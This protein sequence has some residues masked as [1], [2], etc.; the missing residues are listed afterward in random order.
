MKINQAVVFCIAVLLFPGVGFPGDLSSLS[1]E[2]TI[3]AEAH[4]LELAEPIDISSDGELLL[5]FR[6]GQQGFELVNT[7]TGQREVVSRTPCTGYFASISPDK[8]YVCFKDFVMVDGRRLQRPTLYEIARQSQLPLCEPVFTAGNPVVSARGQIAFTV[9]PQLII[10]SPDLSR[11]KEVDLGAV[12]NVLT[13][14]PDGHRLAFGEADERISWIEIDSGKR[15]SVPTT[16]LHGYQ[17]Q[18]SP[19][20]RALLARSSSGEI[21]ACDLSTGE[22][23]SFGAARAAAWVDGDTVALVR[24][25]VPHSRV[26]GTQLLKARLSDGVI[27]TF[28]T[29][30]GNAE[31]AIKTPVAA[32]VAEDGINLTDTRTGAMSKLAVRPLSADALPDAAKK[33]LTGTPATGVAKGAKAVVKLAGVPYIH[34]LYDTAD[35]FPGGASCNATAALMAIQYYNRLPAHPITCTSGGTHISNYGFYI[36]S[37]YTYN[38]HTYNIPS[39]SAWGSTYAGYYG[40]FGYFLQDLVGS[41]LQ[42]SIRLKEWITYH[43]LSSATDDSVS[44]ETGITKARTE[45]NAGYPVVVLCDITSAGHYLT[46]IGYLT[47][48]HT[49]IFNDPYGNKAISYPGWAGAGV[50]YD[51]PGYNNGYPNLIGVVRYIYARGTDNAAFVSQTVTNGTTYAPGQ[52]FSCTWTMNNN[53]TTTWTSSGYSLNYV[54]GTQMGAPTVNL[55]SANVAPGGNAS[56]PINFT[57]PSTPGS[58]TVTMRMN[59]A[60][61]AFFGAQVSLTINVANPVPVITV[62]PAST[63]RD[64]GQTATFT[65]AA[66]GATTYQWQKNGVNLAGKTT[67]TLTLANVQLADAGFYTVV[68]GNAAGTVTSSAAQLVVTAAGSGA[69]T[70]TGLRGCYYDNPDF[71]ALRLSRLDGPVNFDWGTGA[72]AGGMGVD[73][74]S[75]RWTGQ[76]QPRYSQTYTFYTTTDDGVRLWVNGVLLIDYWA[77]QAATER[78]G[79]IALVAGQK[80]DLRLE[81]YENTGSAVAQLRWSSASQLKELIP[82]AQLYRPAP[83]LAAVGAQTVAENSLLSV[84][85]TLVAWD[86]IAAVTPLEDFE[87]YGD[88]AP[89]DQIMFRKPGSSGS[90]SGFLDGAVTNY[91]VPTGSFPGGNLS[92]RAMRVYWSFQAGTTNPWLRLTTYNAA[93]RPNPIVEITRSLWFDLHTD[94]ALQVGLGLRE[95]NPTGAIGEDGGGS[96]PIEFVG[97]SGVLGTAPVPERTVLAGSWTTLKFDL[98][99]EAVTSFTGNGVLESTTGKAVLE[100]LA[101]VPAG[102]LGVYNVYLDNFVQVQPAVLSY[103][104]EPG[105]PAGA[106]IDANTGV[107]TWQPAVGQGPGTYTITVRVRDLGTPEVSGTTSFTVTVKAAPVITGQPQSLGVGVGSNATFTVTA[108]GT[109][110]LYYQ[111]R[112]DGTAIGGATGS[113]YTRV[114]VQ[115]ADAGLYSVVVSNAVGSVESAAAELSVWAVETPPVIVTPPQSQTVVAGTNVAFSVV[116]TGTAPLWYQWYRDGNPLAGA[117]QSQY[118]KAGVQ[119]ADAGSYMV[120]V[121]N[122]V[123]SVSSDPALLIVLEPPVIVTPPQSQAVV[124]GTN[125]AFSVVAAGTAPLWYQWSRDGNPL[126]GATQSQYAKASVQVADAGSY[127]VVVSNQVGSVTSGAAVLTVYAP[128]EILVQPVSQAVAVGSEASF[129]VSAGGSPPLS[130]QWQLNG[131]AVAGATDSRYTVSSVQVADVGMYS[132]AVSNPY[133]SVT[134]LAA[135]LT[136]TGAVV[137]QDD[138]ET[139]DLAGWTVAGGSATELEGSSAQNHTAGGGCSARVDHSRDKMYHNLGVEV[140]GRLR[141]GWWIYDG[142]QSRIFG[143]VRAYAGPGYTESGQMQQ[144]LGAGKYNS[145]TLSGEVWD[146][147]KYQGRVS[148]GANVGWFNLN[149][150]GAPGRSPGWHRFEIERLGDGTT[151][152][153][154]VDGILGRTIL[155]AAEATIDTL[156]IGSVASGSTAGEGWLDDVWVEY[157]DAPVIVTPPAGQTV[158]AGEAATLSVVAGNTVLSY[159]WYL[160]GVAVAGATGATLTIAQAQASDAGSYTVVVGNGL[161][162][163]TG[164]PAELV[165]T[166]PAEV[167]ITGAELGAGT[168]TLRWDAQVGQTYRVQYK[169]N[170][171][172]AVWTDGA[173]VT[174]VAV[175]ASAVCSLADGA[176]VVPRRFFRIMVV[177]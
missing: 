163:V 174:A 32:L 159:R 126:A 177:N 18:F 146:S 168:L 5:L 69:G 128:P 34:Q 44:G 130:Y 80:Y 155:G 137:F 89:T 170:L 106:A 58:Y 176:G 100:S 101:L 74:F 64:P 76:V 169:N 73:T 141:A 85:L 71:S 173:E 78:S 92:A 54:S 86:Q 41:S 22:A 172:D 36:S 83:E 10:L 70:G 26:S 151:I 93:T 66:T 20:G 95:T 16:W 175:T 91:N 111:W 104:L 148:Y 123:G 160:N 153:F 90:T 52:S 121:S 124:A 136:L 27:S 133:G 17:A 145:V 12:V 68:V 67:A 15:G 140:G 117:T 142:E 49:L 23:R 149:A 3:F 102:G 108:T 57:A 144:L 150:P 81:Y 77:G 46:C 9:G 152:N 4:E 134:S 118:A 109:A 105:A 14:S 25:S 35:N 122:Q 113:S 132:V 107:F 138:F 156:L 1:A 45:I 55:I 38:G 62:Q 115:L 60:S 6:P 82:A 84:P 21:T 53:G 61:G 114:G 110:P 79:S 42:R 72:P 87:S 33:T 48:Q 56:I 97:V 98:P 103:A 96:G 40:G 125:V 171:T 119:V 167:R 51:W 43:G 112:K 129:S 13:F 30:E 28:L 154:Y 165:V 164:G 116:A 139:C 147:S 19:D 2:P 59:N 11:E 24:K 131:T 47:G 37:I 31:L 8:K 39:S 7:Q 161:G 63:T 157:L 75:V 50:Y 127:T 94:K 120:V 65:V 99:R 88:G 143:E 29:K 166:S 158:A 135:A 162:E